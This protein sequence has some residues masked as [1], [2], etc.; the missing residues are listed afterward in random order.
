M[1]TLLYKTPFVHCSHDKNHPRLLMVKFTANTVDM[2]EDEYKEEAVN[3]FL[4]SIRLRATAHIINMREMAFPISPS[5]QKWVENQILNHP[6]SP[7]KRNAVILSND[8]ITRMNT[9]QIIDEVI[10]HMPFENRY[11]SNE[12]EAYNWAKEVVTL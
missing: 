1:A 7:L 2:R 11:F 10:D 9:E 4:T 12:E 6:D 5:L 8:L 3:I